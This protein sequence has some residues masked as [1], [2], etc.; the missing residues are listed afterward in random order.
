MLKAWFWWSVRHNNFLGTVRFAPR[1][2]LCVTFL[3]I[4]AS[5]A[6]V[7]CASRLPVTLCVTCFGHWCHQPFRSV[8]FAHCRDACVTFMPQ[9]AVDRKKI[10]YST[11]FFSG[12]G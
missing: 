6:F 7:R 8:C 1:M 4:G 2:T 12:W 9:F 3:A 5:K 11:V 10:G